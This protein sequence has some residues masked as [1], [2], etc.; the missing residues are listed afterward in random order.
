MIAKS[1][2]LNI[3]S[4]R[5]VFAAVEKRMVYSNW[6]RYFPSE[7]ERTVPKTGKCFW[8]MLYFVIQRYLWLMKGNI[9]NKS[10][11]FKIFNLTLQEAEK[12]ASCFA[13]CV[14]RRFLI[15]Q[16]L[17]VKLRVASFFQMEG[18]L[19]PLFRSLGVK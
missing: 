14:C 10:V 1:E 9:D 4:N 8:Y 19:A 5:R 11:E 16:F 6:Q 17:S 3:L 7:S 12:S 15:T 18:S 2:I 13:D